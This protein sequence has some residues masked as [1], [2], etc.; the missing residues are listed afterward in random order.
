MS[1]DDDN[2][3]PESNLPAEAGTNDWVGRR[4]GEF[5]VQ[6]KLGQGGMAEVFLAEQTSLKRQVAIKLL[7]PEYVKDERYLKRF[8]HEAMAAGGL[9]HPNIVQVYMVSDADGVNFIAQEYVP[10]YT[11]KDYIKKKGPLEVSVALHIMRQVATA[12]E[13]AGKQGIVHRDIKPENILLTKKGEAKVADFGLAQLTLGGERVNLTQVGVTMGTPLYMS[14]EQVKGQP[15]DS[16]SD[17]YSF[18]VMS[19]HMLAG[20]TP[21]QASQPLSVAVKHLHEA[22]PLLSSLRPDLPAPVVDFVHWLMAKKKES[23]PADAGVALAEIRKLAKAYATKTTSPSAASGNALAGS[24]TAIS[25]G[26]TPLAPS[27]SVSASASTSAPLSMKSII[28]WGMTC[29]AILAGSAGL[30]W[31]MRPADPFQQ[32]APAGVTV[33]KLSSAEAQLFHAMSSPLDEPRWLAV[34][35]YYGADPRNAQ[36]ARRAREG[37]ASLYLRTQRRTEAKAV[38]EKLVSEG[39]MVGDHPQTATGRAGLAVV[40]ALDGDFDEARRQLKDF[41]LAKQPVS[42]SMRQ[43]LDEAK[44]RILG[45]APQ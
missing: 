44:S 17:L 39:Q 26:D 34:L 23:R 15:L 5:V 2:D 32:P 1:D 25:P 7:R 30:A 40:A 6:R 36:S 16:R 42:E 35:D 28:L 22:P 24:N 12:L 3:A 29:V 13:V 18:G 4:L 10:G 45:N 8:R 31:A 14:P 43:L 37:L 41:E 11:L 19:Y 21:F 33:E 9:V 27:A 20:K 38:Y